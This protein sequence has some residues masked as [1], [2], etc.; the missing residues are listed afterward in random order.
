MSI[1]DHPFPPLNAAFPASEGISLTPAA[2]QGV[3][4]KRMTDVALSLAAIAILSPLF[5]LIA[6]AVALDSRGPV[7]FRQRRTGRQGKV[8]SIF[9]FRT[10]H[11]LEDGAAVQASAGGRPAHHPVGTLSAGCQPG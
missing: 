10:M 11:V 8:F 6:L 5:A 9:K 3:C 4:V 7:F 2:G 1:Q